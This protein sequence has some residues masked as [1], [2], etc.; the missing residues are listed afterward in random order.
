M[1]NERIRLGIVLAVVLPMAF[2]P[3]GA[4]ADPGPETISLDAASPSNVDPADLLNPGLS[5]QVLAAN[6]G[7]A[8]G[9]EVDALSAGIDAVQDENIVYFSVHRASVGAAGGPLA[10]LDVNGQATLN[11]QAGDV[12]VTT[13]A[14]GVGSVP[15]GI[16]SL[17]VNQ[18]FYGEIP[19]TGPL[20]D[21]TGN[22]QDNLD[23]LCFEEFDLTGDL[24]QDRWTFF[25][26]GA[27]S[28]SLGAFS[29]PADIFV[30]HPGVPGM[31][32]FASAA[33]MGLDPDDDLDALVLLDLD[34][35]GMLSPGDRALF[36]LAP[37]SPTLLSL[38]LSSA[39]VFETTFDGT[40]AVRYAHGSLGLL[41]ED[42]VDALEVQIPE[43]ATMALLGLGGLAVLRR[44]AA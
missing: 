3:C 35:D 28:P 12:Y 36:S 34:T 15:V 23:A 13:D 22:P 29:S 33:S 14:A 11:Q 41:G 19:V 32:L 9:D 8:A 27:L 17:Y 40:S 1:K 21:N 2:T 18:N 4:L 20:T 10:P 7:L 31:S 39:D 25:S 37:S 24:L 6:L 38:S 16:H 5:T 43:P 42:D 26:L 30:S 44:R